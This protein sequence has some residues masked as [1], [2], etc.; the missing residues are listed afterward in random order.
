MERHGSGHVVRI[1]TS[2]VDASNLDS[3]SARTHAPGRPYGRGLRHR[4]GNPL[5][6]VRELCDG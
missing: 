6:R 2:L 3:R 5:S 1:T 4:R